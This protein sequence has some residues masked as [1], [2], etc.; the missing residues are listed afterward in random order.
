MNLLDTNTDSMDTLNQDY[1]NTW[2]RLGNYNLGDGEYTT[3]SDDL[4]GFKTM[5]NWHLS[6]GML[7]AGLTFADNDNRFSWGLHA[8]YF[9][10][11]SIGDTR[12][13]FTA[14]ETWGGMPYMP[15]AGIRSLVDNGGFVTTDG[16]RGPDITEWVPN[17]EY[18]YGDSWTF[19][20][21][22]SWSW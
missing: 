21:S 16:G 6:R 8:A 4:D 19:M 15:G 5:P 2:G 11:R 7:G 13:P 3:P 14:H 10:A 17:E 20:I 12:S 9:P 18:I 1:L 22:W